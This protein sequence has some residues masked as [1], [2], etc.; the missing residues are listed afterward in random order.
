MI[1]D[2]AVSSTISTPVFAASFRVDDAANSSPE[3]PDVVHI[4]T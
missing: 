2:Y 4:E 1:A 3:E